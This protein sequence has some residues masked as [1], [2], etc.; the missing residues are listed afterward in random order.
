MAT[1]LRFPLVAAT[2]LVG[3][4]VG[5]LWGLGQMP[6][7]QAIATIYALTV[8]AYRAVSMIRDLFRGRWGIDL[9]AVTAIA[10][11]LVVGEYLASLIIVLML[12]GGDALEEFAHGRATHE[13]KA[14]LERA[15]RTAHRETRATR[16]KRF[17]W[18]ASVPETHCWSNLRNRPSGRSLALPCRD[19][20]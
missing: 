15:P 6:A 4:C 8:A 19:F 5:V 10:S 11:T 16:W 7:A 14:L 12:T 1:I 20:R 17:P 3:V 2:L 13:L 9:L 18:G